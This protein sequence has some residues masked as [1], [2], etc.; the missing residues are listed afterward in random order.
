MPYTIFSDKHIRFGAQIGVGFIQNQYKK[1]FVKFLLDSGAL[2][3]GSFRLKS[4]RESPYFINTGLF[5]DGYMITKLGEFY[6]AA[7]IDVVGIDFD[8]VFGPPYKGIPLAVA[9]SMALAGRRINRGW[10]SYRKE[11]KDHG[12]ATEHERTK[13]QLQKEL[14]IGHEITD[15]SRVLLVDDVLTTGGT[16]EEALDILYR[17]ADNVKVVAGLIAV[18]RQELDEQ[19]KDAVAEFKQKTG[20]Q[21]FSIATTSD[22]LEYLGEFGG[23]TEEQ[24]TAFRSYIFRWGTE[25]ARRRLTSQLY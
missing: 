7:A 18:D 16:K 13:S 23:V 9:T 6:A 25:E 24:T 15:G 3:V 19:G 4:G 22:I 20:V 8:T 1:E 5:D 17:V 11:V 14:I 2:R 12:E 21:F 10:S